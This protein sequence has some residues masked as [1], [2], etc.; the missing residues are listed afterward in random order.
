VLLEHDPAW[1]RFC[2]AVLGFPR[3]GEAAAGHSVFGALSRRERQVLGLITEGLSNTDIADRLGI[4]EKTVRN[5]ASNV[6]DK[7]GVWSRAQGTVFARAM[8]STGTLTAAGM[9]SNQASE[10]ALARWRGLAEIRRFQTSS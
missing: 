2:E 4:S 10:V 7:L 5:H 9:C 3:G 8:A 6:F 1:D